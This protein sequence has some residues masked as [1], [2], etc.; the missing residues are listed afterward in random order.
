M[1][2]NVP[3]VISY[4]IFVCRFCTINGNFDIFVQNVAII[5]KK[6]LYFGK[7]CRFNIFVD[8]GLSVAKYFV[9]FVHFCIN[10]DGSRFNA[11]DD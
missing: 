11:T 1:V 5:K 9:C 8:G 6:S 3:Y 2:L 10:R 7:I 4:F